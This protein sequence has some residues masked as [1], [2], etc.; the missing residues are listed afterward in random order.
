MNVPKH[1]TLIR[2]MLESRVKKMKANGPV[3][4]A[5]L[6][7]TYTR[8]GRSGCRCEKGDKH[9][10]NQITF[11][12]KGKTKTVYIP[13]DLVPEV[14]AWIKEHKRLKQLNQEI[15]QLATA[16]IQTYVSA[17]KNKAGRR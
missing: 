11:K 5:S 1:P 16:R 10:K 14:K 13:L 15:S 7:Q 4:A 2:R 8:C 6:T 3:L 9:L 12:V 17:A